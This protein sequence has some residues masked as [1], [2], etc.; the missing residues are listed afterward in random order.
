[1]SNWLGTNQGFAHRDSSWSLETHRGPV[2]Q[3][4]RPQILGRR[5]SLIV[6]DR[7]HIMLS[8][9]QLEAVSDFLERPMH[10]LSPRVYSKRSS[11]SRLFSF[12]RLLPVFNPVSWMLRIM[13]GNEKGGPDA[14]VEHKGFNIFR[15]KCRKQPRDPL[16]SSS[17]V[18]VPTWVQGK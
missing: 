17:K 3:S 11:T 4:H 7:L 5:K 10:T 15:R 8:C 6:T 16:A 14:T 18:A 1:M 12:M 13:L 2:M 9:K